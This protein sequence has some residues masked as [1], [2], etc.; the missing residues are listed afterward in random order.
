MWDSIAQHL[1]QFSSA[2]LTGVDPE[3]YPFS[4]RCKPEP[5][6]A[7]GV[8]RIP[9]SEAVWIERGPAGLLCHQHDD[10]LWNLDSFVVRGTLE[11][12]EGGWVLRP[13]GLTPGARTRGWLGMLR[14]VW[15]C[16]RGARRYLRRRGLARPPVS[17]DEF[18]ALWAEA[19]LQ[20]QP[21]GGHHAE[22]G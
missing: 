4:V 12:D 19:C 1:T 17:W 10:A 8:L 2:V 3:G 16:R 11:K 15:R 18:A 21:R 20:G 9:I 5:D 14:F 13:E 6:V 7:Q 22:P